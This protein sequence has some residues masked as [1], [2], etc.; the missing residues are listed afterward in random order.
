MLAMAFAIMSLHR[1]S[2]SRDAAAPAAMSLRAGRVRAVCLGLC[3]YAVA[4][5][6][7]T[8][9]GGGSGGAFG[10]SGGSAGG[11]RGGSAGGGRGG[12]AGAQLWMIPCVTALVSQ[13]PPSGACTIQRSDGGSDF[14]ACYA[15]GV[16]VSQTTTSAGGCGYSETRE[17][18]RSDG[19]LCFSY[20][21]TL[22]VSC[23][24]GDEIYRD[25]NGEIVAQGVSGWSPQQPTTVTC[26]KTGE[27]CRGTGGYYGTDCQVP[28]AAGCTPGVCP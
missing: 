13:C 11:G 5:N 8:L 17:V 25:G 10:G 14:R 3:L 27:T 23:E 1:S 16:T 6:S 19:S 2:P 7:D 12:S 15:S 9:A 26:T 24:Y 18:R 20:T 22:R 21:W 4:C 28:L